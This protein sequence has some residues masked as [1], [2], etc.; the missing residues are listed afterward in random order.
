MR[1]VIV[2]HTGGPEVLE[3]VDKPTPTPGPGQ[4]L[5][6]HAAIGL[7]FIDIYHRTG[8]YP[9]KTPFT[10][11]SEASGV[12]EAVGEGV[13]QAKPG[14]RVAYAGSQGAYAEMNLVAADRLVHLPAD[15][16]FEL[17]AAS[18]LK[19][20]TAEFL[21]ERVWPALQPGDPVLVHAAAG[22]VGG[23][24]VQWLKHRGQH[25]IAAVGG[26][27]KSAIAKG[28]GAD[29]VLDYDSEDIAARVRELTGGAG[30]RV[31]Y[32]SVG[33]ATFEASLASLAKRGLMVCF[34]NAS[35]PAPAIE[36]GRL[37]RLGSLYLTR[38]TLFDYIATT[39][40]LDAAAAGLFGL[41]GDGA[42][43]I[44]I[45]Q[46]WPLSEV[47]QAHAALETRKTV[48]ATVLIP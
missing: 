19:G 42:L 28:H 32:D 12:V 25:V 4:A 31:V 47:S 20:M 24:L 27:K 37:A 16:P 30:V 9:M 6:R 17:A 21:A 23:I 35:G 39:A 38:P 22:G 10:P 8:L 43:K 44:D 18:M 46:S 13:A 29:A 33:K 11:G 5:I 36:P 40:E 34:G 41:I 1:A 14:D 15:V 3:L 48:G 45:G 2:S 26:A 7:N